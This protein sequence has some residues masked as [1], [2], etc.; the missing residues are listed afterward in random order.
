MSSTVQDLRA[1]L[2]NLMPTITGEE[3][4]QIF[5]LIADLFEQ[6]NTSNVIAPWSGSTT[7][8]TPEAGNGNPSYADEGTRLWRSKVNDNTNHQPPSD[9]QITEDTYWIEVSKAPVN[10]VKEWAPGIYG[11]GLVIV[12]FEDDFYKLLVAQRPFESSNI[13][14]EIATNKWL[15][16]TAGD[17]SDGQFESNLSD[18]LLMSQDF[19][20]KK[21]TIAELEALGNL[22]AIIVDAFY[23]DV[24]ASVTGTRSVSLSGVTTEVLEVGSSKN[25][26]LSADF[27]RG[28]ITNGDGSVAG[29]LVGP[30]TAYTFRDPGNTI[31]AHTPDDPLDNNQQA[32]A[33]AF[34]MNSRGSFTWSVTVD[35]DAGTTDYFDNKDTVSPDNNL[36]ANEVAGSASGSS[37]TVTTRFRYFTYLG[38]RGTSPNDSASIR[39]LATDYL[40]G[41]DEASF[42]LFIP[43]GTSEVVVYT[44]AG[45]AVSATNPATNESFAPSVTNVSVNDIGGTSRSYTKN[46]IDL[47]LNGFPQDANFS[48]Y[49]G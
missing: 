14:T 29:D 40:N 10:I 2:I 16:L 8:D 43:A 27:D 15:N 24:L 7:Y 34:Q 12:F 31:I 3:L 37:N 36:A 23:E 6:N 48:F 33:P 18:S 22:S 5:S 20:R 44:L 38:A 32:Q 41:S 19:G 45:K 26:L 28:Q 13:V 42:S 21:Y 47:G 46:L 35:Y 49:I 25:P 17:G 1:L 39:A 9:P 30:P 11:E 4:E